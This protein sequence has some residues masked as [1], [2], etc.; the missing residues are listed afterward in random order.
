M[1]IARFA[2]GTL[3]VV[4]L[5]ACG[6]KGESGTGA[7][8]TSGTEAA[9]AGSYPGTVNSMPGTDTTGVGA[10]G[11]DVDR[12]AEQE[13]ERREQARG[14]PGVGRRR[15]GELQDLLAVAGPQERL[16]DDL[17]RVVGR[18]RQ[19]EQGGDGAHRVDP[20]VD[21]GVPR[22][23]HSALEREVAGVGHP[24]HLVG[25]AEVDGDEGIDV[26]DVDIRAFELRQ[27]LEDGLQS[28]AVPVR[29][30]RGQVVAALNVSAPVS[31]GAAKDVV[32][33]ML[34]PLQQTAADIGDDLGGNASAKGAMQEWSRGLEH[35]A[36]REL[37]SGAALPLF[38]AA[39]PE[40][41][42]I[43]IRAAL[44]KAGGHRQ[45][46]AKLLGCGRNTLTR[47]IRALD[48]D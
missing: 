14:E 33:D 30:G 18:L 38:Q 1:N 28:L 48:L 12:Q 17:R 39:V 11:V 15:M 31:R 34:P 2:V 16:V 3:I 26:V 35:W 43:L 4:A 5:G 27:E 45:E 36:E 21:D 10:T 7:D 46:A 37:A 41:E 29:D 23:L 9:E 40:M 24:Q 13:V 25:H 47:K 42:R 44:N 6:K 22:P 8:S 19:R 20:Q 32:R